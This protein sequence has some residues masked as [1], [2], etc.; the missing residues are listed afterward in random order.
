MTS[1]VCSLS[2]SVLTPGTQGEPNDCSC[3]HQN[4]SC[5]FVKASATIGLSPGS[6]SKQT[7]QQSKGES[8]KVRG[9][10]RDQFIQTC[11][12]SSF[13]FLVVRPGA[14]SSILAPSSDA[15]CPLLLVANIAPILHNLLNKS[16]KILLL[17]FP[18]NFA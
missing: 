12:K 8:K 1:R 11:A 15:G 17:S 14:P 13:L 9:K 7:A 3:P 18:L 10:F 2:V 5:F 4:A 16:R 6:R